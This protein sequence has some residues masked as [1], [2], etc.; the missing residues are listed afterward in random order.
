MPFKYEW[1][2]SKK[3]EGYNEPEHRV[4]FNWSHFENAAGLEGFRKS[5]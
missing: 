3:N 2:T 1:E 4:Y 5:V